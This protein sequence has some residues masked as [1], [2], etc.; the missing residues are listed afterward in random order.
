MPIIS[1][2]EKI[3]VFSVTELNQQ[4]RLLLEGHFS[5][6]KVEGEISNLARPRS[7]H[8]YFSLKDKDAQVRCAFF[9]GY[10]SHCQLTPE[11]GLKVQ[12]SARVSL[13]ENRGDY[14]LIVER[15]DVGKEGELRRAF[16]QLKRE[17]AAKGL[18]EQRHKK[19]IPKHP[20]KLGV[21]TSA[22]G[23]A[24]RD[25]LSTLKKRAPFLPVLVYP[26]QVQGETAK[27][28]IV[29]QIEKANHRNECDVLIIA[30]G[31]GSLEDLW[32][33]NE[34]CVAHAIFASDIPIIS[35]VGHETDT[36]ICDMV[37]DLR[38]ETPTAA[39]VLAAPAQ[40][41]LLSLLQFK[42][43]ALNKSMQKVLLALNTKLD[44]LKSHLTLAPNTLHQHTQKLD[45]LEKRLNYAIR[46]QMQKH[47]QNIEQ[48]TR[49]LNA[50]NPR[51]KLNQYHASLDKL[52]QLLISQMAKSLSKHRHQ[53]HQAMKSLNL[54]SPLN[55]LDRGYTLLLNDKGQ[56]ISSHQEATINDNVTVKLK[57]GMLSCQV[58]G[59]TQ[60]D[61]V[62]T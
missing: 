6:V 48:R 35:G 43:I 4:S 37:A 42:T 23:A 59:I 5:L 44:Y 60:N 39:A 28:Q 56:I 50:L 32:S 7:G 54:L 49:C 33:F 17:L 47:Q 52:K 26:C 38:A 40:S 11:D 15:I 62:G 29:S 21:I 58:K 22:S 34:P 2:E 41:E 18:F 12:V 3:K 16:E 30:R 9:K 45:A 57:D 25:I 1:L 13:F 46:Q 19:I 51:H 10:A 24:L 53:L 61:D 27:K 31:G 8:I 14:Q 55:T 36:T 20:K